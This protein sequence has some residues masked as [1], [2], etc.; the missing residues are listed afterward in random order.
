MS[1]MCRSYHVSVN[2]IY[3]KKSAFDTDACIS[4]NKRD[5][6]YFNYTSRVH[7]KVHRLA[8]K[9]LCHSNKTWHSLNSTFPDTNC[10]ASSQ[11]KTHLIINSG[12]WKLV[13]ETFRERHGKLTKGALFHQDN[14]LAHNYVCGCNGCCALLWLWTG[15]SPSIF[16][17]FG[18]MWLYSAPQHE[19]TLGWEAVYRIDD[20]VIICS[21]G[22]LYHGNSSAVTPME[23]VCGP[24]GRLCWKINNLVK[25]DHC[26]IVSLWTFQPTLVLLWL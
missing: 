17:W 11:K 4:G 12:L 18:T 7:W 10:N 8:K 5:K 20:E 1:R 2:S 24:Q 19:H 26:I 13:P 22:L 16:S 25:I 6:H 3:F 15:S 21:W 14:T 9:E 23:E